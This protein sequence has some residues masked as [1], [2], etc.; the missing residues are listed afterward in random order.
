MVWVCI[1]QLLQ[2]RKGAVCTVVE[3]QSCGIIIQEGFGV[4]LLFIL[5]FVHLI[6]FLASLPPLDQLQL[7]RIPI[8]SELQVDENAIVR[9]LVVSI[10]D[11][12]P[13]ALQPI[14]V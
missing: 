8:L 6:I 12:T 5:T 4:V 3:N 1:I 9:L 13:M 2:S 7:C 14:Q 11:I 10:V